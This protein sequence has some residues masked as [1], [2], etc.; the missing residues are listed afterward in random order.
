MRHPLQI[1]TRR[2]YAATS[3]R[4]VACRAVAQAVVYARPKLDDY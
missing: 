3:R 1:R 2:H 4:Q